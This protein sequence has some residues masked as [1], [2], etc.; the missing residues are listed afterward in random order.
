MR[1][2]GSEKMISVME[3]LGM[4]DGVPIEHK[5]VN[6]SIANAQKRVEGIHF[7]SRK[8]VIEYD[9][10]MNMQRKSIYG[11][12]REVLGG[13]KT[14]ELTIDLVEEFVIHQVATIALKKYPRLTGNLMTLQKRY[15]KSLA[16]MWIW[17]A[18]VVVGKI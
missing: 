13:E 16:S 6:K 7:D 9:D 8:N 1:I 2:F 11:L 14:E 12:R 18:L 17:L 5:W 4:E 10:V 3:R 15:S